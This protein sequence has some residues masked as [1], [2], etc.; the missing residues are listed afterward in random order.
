MMFIASKRLG[1][2]MNGVSRNERDIFRKMV[3]LSVQV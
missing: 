2:V 1:P 3:S